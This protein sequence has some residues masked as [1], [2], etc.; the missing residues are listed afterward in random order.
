MIKKLIFDLTQISD[1]YFPGKYGSSKEIEMRLG[2]FI[3]PID[4]TKLNLNKLK[5]K[6]SFLSKNSK[7]NKHY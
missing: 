6:S 4:V 1:K 2:K 5:R 3:K 7:K